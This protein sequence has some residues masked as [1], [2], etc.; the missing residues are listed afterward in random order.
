MIF[1]DL[2]AGDAVFLDANTLVYHFARDPVF[3]AACS[4][5]LQRIENGEISGFTST[6][7]LTESAHRLMTTEAIAVFGWPLAG[8]AQRLRRHPLEV[9]KLSAFQYAIDTIVKSQIRIIATS[10]A[11]IT[12]AA[13]VS[14]RTGLLS[15]DALIVVVMQANNLNKL[16]SSDKDFTRVPGIALYTPA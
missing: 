3:G 1:A 13:A 9:Q 14:R 11:V 15:N 12:D 2:Q 16:A 5:L 8:I 7:I 6:H 10:S 4:Q